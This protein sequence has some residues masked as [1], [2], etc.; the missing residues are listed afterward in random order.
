MPGTITDAV[1]ALAGELA[2]HLVDPDELAAWTGRFFAEVQS[3]P[4][5][6]LRRRAQ[7]AR[8]CSRPGCSLL[9]LVRA[10]ARRKE[11]LRGDGLRRPAGP[12]GPG[13]PRPPGGR[14]DRAGPLPGGAARRV[15]GHQPR[16]GGAAQRAVRRRAPGDRGRRPV[17][18][19]LRLARG[20]RRHPGPVPGRVRP[21]RRR[22]RPPALALTTS[23][24]NRPEILQVANAL[25]DAAAGG[26][27]AGA[28]SCAPRSASRP[29][30]A[31]QPRRRGRRHGALRAAADVRRRG[32]LDRRQRARRLAG[33]GPDAGRAARAHPG[34]RSARPP[35]C[36][37]GS[38]ARSRRSRR[39]CARRGLPVE[40]VGLG[41]LLDTPEVRDVVCTLRVLA[42]PTDGAALLRLLTGARWRIG[43][44]D[45]VALHRRA[46]AIAAA[47]RQVTADDE[48][49]DRRRPARRGDP[50]GGAGRPRPGA[51]V[52]GRGVRAAAGVRPGAGAAALPAGPVAAGPD[53]RHRADHR[54]GRGGRGPGRPGRRRRRRPGPGPPGRARRRGGPVQRR[55]AA[56]AP[57]PGSWPSWPPPR[58]RSAG[59]PRARSRW[60][61]A[62]CRSSPRTPPRAWSGTWWRWPA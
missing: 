40:V 52:L 38:A 42:D 62:R 51:G 54:P 50:G 21:R 47:R 43:P 5:P 37:S 9:P 17:P 45:L 39:R 24:R 59:S 23:W 46:R 48:P 60:S 14:R 12:G 58:T 15:P 6:G 44:R 33:R 16:P 36:W 22:A 1:L 13:G 53:R 57:C 41:G 19:H 29:D 55:D 30:P 28:A 27:G 61:R 7:G 35:R 34:R 2:E 11:R 31:P 25:S 49:G 10:Y 8:R 18:V 3:R 32:R 26:R 20:Q 4:G 56:G